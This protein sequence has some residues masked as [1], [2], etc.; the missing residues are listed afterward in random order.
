LNYDIKDGQ[1]KQF[2]IQGQWSI[3]L[4]TG[5]VDESHNIL[6]NSL[7]LS[8]SVYLDNIPV[9]LKTKSETIK[10]SLQDKMINFQIEFDYAFSIINDQ[11]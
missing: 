8:E 4:N 7:L 3:K 10:T 1:N 9:V 2:N 6:I 5:W 11:V